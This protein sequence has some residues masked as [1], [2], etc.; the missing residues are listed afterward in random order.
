MKVLILQ[1]EKAVTA[2]S[3]LEWLRLKKLDY[4]IYNMWENEPFPETT[5]FYFL[6]VCGGTM[7]VDQ[8]ETFPWLLEEK[9][10]VTK[11]IAEKKLILGLCLGGQ[12]IAEAL[13]A[14]VGKLLLDETGWHSVDLFEGSAN[15]TSRNLIAFQWHSYGFQF[16][17]ETTINWVTERAI[18]KRLPPPSESSQTEGVIQAGLKFQPQLQDWYFQFLDRFTTLA[19]RQNHS[20]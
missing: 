15:S 17:P 4:L 9:K 19:F 11:S 13:G 12:L 8:A 10:L 3:T 5:D 7:N 2:G 18:T 16:H 20:D 6:I 1:H 14:E